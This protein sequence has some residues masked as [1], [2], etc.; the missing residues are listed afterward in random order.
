[1]GEQTWPRFAGLQHVAADSFSDVD[2]QQLPILQRPVGDD[3]AATRHSIG[4]QRLAYERDSA[5]SLYGHSTTGGDQRTIAPGKRLQRT[6]HE[7]DRRLARGRWHLFGPAAVP[8]A[9]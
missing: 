2:G 5:S 6:R 4:D 3:H 1:M 9:V 7:G 8:E